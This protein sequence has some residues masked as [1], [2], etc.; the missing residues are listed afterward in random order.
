MSFLKVVSVS[1]FG[2]NVKYLQ[3]AE[4]LMR[5]ISENLPDWKATFFVGNS[6][7]SSTLNHLE[8]AGARLIHV[9]EKES[10]AST[11]WRFRVDQLGDPKW[12]VFRDADSLV[13]RRDASAITQWVKSGLSAHIIRD[14][15]FH[16]A[17]ILAGLWGLQPMKES[18]FQDEVMGFRFE[19]SYGSDQ[20]FLAEVVY[21]RI[22]S[23][24]LIHASFHKHEN[25]KHCADF[26][27]GST[28]VGGFCGESVTERLLVRTY[29]R[30]HR[31]L[32]STSCR[33]KR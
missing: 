28:R 1:L 32:D 27:V 9:N 24:A 4:F 2:K 15:P 5:S 31:L 29:A 21:P 23:S 12:V 11:A 14:H 13:T 26:L 22:A 17:K 6:V 19:D 33:C 7:P 25:T 8:A 16:K 20:D 18:W 10:L 30:L 3:G